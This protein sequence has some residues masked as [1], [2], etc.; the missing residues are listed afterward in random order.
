MVIEKFGINSVKKEFSH[1]SVVEQ[2]ED[3]T[4]N[5][6]LWKSEREMFD[7]FVDKNAKILDL[8]CGA[9]RT[10]I[11]LVENGWCNII[12]VD[13][14]ENMIESATK[15]TKERDLDIAFEAGDATNLR[16]ADG[17]FDLVFFSFNGLMCIPDRINRVK[18]MAEINRVLKIG[19]IFIFTTHDRDL[20]PD[21]FKH[22]WAEE[23]TKWEN[24]TQDSRIIDFGDRITTE[25]NGCE[26]FIHIAASDDIK[27]MFDETGF[28]LVETAMRSEI[29]D[30]NEAVKSYSMDCRFWVAIKYG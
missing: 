8:G 19:G 26:I 15:I 14:S 18:A 6:G 22:I 4:K 5:I 1:D 3:Y 24:G 2:Y 27:K 11:S 20:T 23:K 13:L 30:E 10:T 25:K 7:K 17:E 16:F 9:G 21:E 12:G 28:K 29:A